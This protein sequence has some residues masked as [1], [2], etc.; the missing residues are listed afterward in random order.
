MIFHPLLLTIGLALHS[1][2]TLQYDASIYGKITSADTTFLASGTSGPAPI[3]YAIIDIA[4]P[5]G[6][7]RQQSGDVD[8]SYS[9][10]GLAGGVYTLRFA[11]TGYVP[12]SLDVRVPEHGAVHLDVTLDRAPATMQTIKVVANDAIPRIP[13]TPASTGAYRPWRIEGERMRTLASLDFPDVIR[14]IGTSP[15][16][17]A[18]PESGA[19]LHSQGGATNHTMLLVDGIPL[20]NA[21]HAG[22]HP[23]VIDPDAVA[24]ITSY[25]EPRAG[26]GGRLSGVVE[27]NTLTALPDS[28]HV[29]TSIWPTGIRT[30]TQLQFAG[31]SALVGA[32]RNYARPLEGNEREPLTLRPN[33]VF[34]TASVPFVGGSLTGLF[35]SSADAISFDAAVTPAH[36][37]NRF[38][39]TSDARALT[40]DRD[41]SSGVSV[42]ARVWQSG[43]AVGTDWLP[44]SGKPMRMGN[45]FTQTAAAATMSW[46]GIAAQTSAGLSLE[47]LRGTYTAADTG[48]VDATV[49]LGINSGLRIGSAFIE[50]SR[51]AG[52]FSATLGERIAV[53]DDKRLLFEPRA[54]LAVSLFKGSTLSAAFA[55]SHQYTQSLYNDESLVDALASLEVPVISGT[56]GIPIASSTAG[57][58]RLD[59]PIGPSALITAGTFVRAFDGLVLPSA[60]GGDPFAT[61]APTSGHGM[62][63]GGSVG[64]R[65]EV[66]RLDMQGG[67]SMSVV[68]REWAGERT[69]RPT[70]APSHDL[71]VSAG[72]RL[73]GSTL[74]RASGFMSAFRSTSPLFGAVTWNWDDELASQREV[75][76]SPQYSPAALGAGRLEPYVRIDIGIRQNFTFR[77][78]L[79]AS[80]FFNIDNLLGRRNAAGLVED[81]SGT[82]THT[83]GMMPRSISFGVGLRF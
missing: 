82:G 15:D 21:V 6:T 57:S 36:F 31:G 44:A 42:N 69:Y 73:G 53:L 7:K 1:Q 55:R 17:P 59:V 9:L 10:T 45:R 52:R 2:D 54:A 70:F 47:Q 28:Q 16:A 83:L 46:G 60:S 22:D 58:M 76:G 29:V 14:A 72:Y 3:G 64:V 75:S 13:G 81:P 18:G 71:L 11:R 25:S 38:D 63:Y 37:G 39:W 43:T 20:Y 48:R 35:T 8:G 41:A 27:V 66:G 5:D 34:A 4:G 77:G 32:R 50:H 56:A 26:V 65:A 33:D 24:D 40:W 74:L 19:G 61:T 67:W 23:G 30:L 49:L 80:A 78:P 12:L 68:T 79:R 51:T 62:A